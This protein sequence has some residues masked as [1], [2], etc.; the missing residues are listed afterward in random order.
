MIKGL[1]Q[2]EVDFILATLHQH[3]PNA[4]I[5]A[6]GSRVS[7]TP[8]KYSDLDICLDNGAPLELSKWDLLDEAF[9][10][11]DLPFKVD[12]SDYHRIS[13]DFRKLVEQTSVDIA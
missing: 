3:V 13:E 5:L 6:F 7:G 12:I 9:E 8:K 11:S 10:E 4:R 1:S 2:K